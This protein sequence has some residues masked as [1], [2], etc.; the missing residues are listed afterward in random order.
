MA[1]V[2]A[3]EPTLF[4]F[5]PT[6]GQEYISFEEEVLPK[7]IK[8]GNLYECRVPGRWND[9]GTFER[10]EQAIFDWTGKARQA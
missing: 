1:G 8:N 5:E 6:S 2:Y 7:V 9:C 3:A 4:S 10:Y